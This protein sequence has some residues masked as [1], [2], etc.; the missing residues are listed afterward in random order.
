MARPRQTPALLMLDTA[1][2]QLEDLWWLL[3]RK[4][5]ISVNLG[6]GR[7]FTQSRAAVSFDRFRQ[8]LLKVLLPPDKQIATLWDFL[9]PGDYP[10]PLPPVIDIPT[11]VEAWCKHSRRVY[12]LDLELQRLLELT[13]LSK[14]TWGELHFPFD[15][16]LVELAEPLLNEDDGSRYSL[17]LLSKLDTGVAGH[18]HWRWLFI[19]E[20]GGVSYE[21]LKMEERKELEGFMR[22]HNWTRAESCCDRL[23]GVHRRRG[24][25]TSGCSLYLPEGNDLL[26]RNSAA[27]LAKGRG[28][29][30]KQ[31]HPRGINIGMWDKMFRI[32]GTLLVY[33]ETVPPD[34]PHI[35][36]R[37][38]PAIQHPGRGDLITDPADIFTI[39]S[40]IELSHEER[41]L[42]GVAGTAE[43]QRVARERAEYGLGP[44]PRQGYLARPRGLGNDPTAK[45]TQWH[46]PTFV[47]RHKLPPEGGLPGGS[48]TERRQKR[49][50]Q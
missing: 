44:H 7:L 40:M 37:P 14:T 49:I 39:G 29:T 6:R 10:T 25:I 12:R 27:E 41:V 48:S 3:H 38:P 13:H 15:S 2:R 1:V 8:H 50:E 5:V 4:N 31:H 17:A 45:R 16:F 26:V 47:N 19:G 22:N 11:G 36:R 35:N 43:E 21:P 18:F 9:P 34:S 28:S 33:L 42:L 20:S 23:L 32:I 46:R 30:P 24:L